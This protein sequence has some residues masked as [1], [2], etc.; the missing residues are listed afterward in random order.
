MVT[1]VCP[2]CR[3]GINLGV[4][5]YEGQRVICAGC[6]ANLEVISL[7]HL[8]LDWV[9]DAPHHNPEEEREWKEFWKTGIQ[10]RLEEL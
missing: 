8:E 2:E 9:Y 4:Q 10:L 3:Y 6:G 1:A 5:P 7:E